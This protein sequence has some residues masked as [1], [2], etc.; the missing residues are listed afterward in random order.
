MTHRQTILVAGAT[1]SIGGSAAAE[2]ARRG[3]KVVLLGRNTPRLSSRANSIRDAFADAGTDQPGADVETL[4]IDFSDVDAVRAA[5]EE[6]LNRFPTIDGLVLSVGAFLQSGPNVLPGE[7]EMMFATNVIGPFL[8]TNLL[9]D[10][11]QQ[12][13]ALVLHVIASFHEDLHWDDLESI[14]NHRPMTAFNRTK[15]CNRVIA[16][17]RS[18]LCP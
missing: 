16:R 17:L 6:A 10:R 5:A 4:V 11:M 18:N 8:S 3:I 7:H 2:L 9:L 1:G 14:K 12:S 15:T 13:D